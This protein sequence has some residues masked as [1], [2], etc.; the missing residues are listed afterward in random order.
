MLI[1]FCRFFLPYLEAKLMILSPIQLQANLFNFL[2]STTT[3]I[4]DQSRGTRRTLAFSVFL[5]I[6]PCWPSTWLWWYSHFCSRNHW[7]SRFAQAS[8]K[9]SA[10]L[11][12][13]FVTRSEL[14]AIAE[15]AAD[16]WQREL[17]EIEDKAK[18][19]FESRVRHQAKFRNILTTRVAT[20][21]WW[22]NEE[23]NGATL[24]TWGREGQDN[25][26]RWKIV[27]YY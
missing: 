23:A 11:K 2:G 1:F 16:D 12:N 26:R 10:T 6:F 25:D 8:A 3:K 9:L 17:K 5:G 20:S 4:Y 14:A 19:E 18:A 7:L 13:P 24:G 15:E 21:V 22:S 27:R